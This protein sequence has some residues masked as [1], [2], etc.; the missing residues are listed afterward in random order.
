[1]TRSLISRGAIVC[2]FCVGTIT[3]ADPRSR[4]GQVVNAQP[5]RE[6]QLGIRLYW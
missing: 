2:A 1:M 4:C 3:C 5:A 6:I